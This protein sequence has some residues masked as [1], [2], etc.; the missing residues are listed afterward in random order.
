MPLIQLQGY[1]KITFSAAQNQ[2]VIVH[3]A[4]NNTIQ[5]TNFHGWQTL[6]KPFSI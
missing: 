4:H 2:T 1:K 3:A 5:M 6:P